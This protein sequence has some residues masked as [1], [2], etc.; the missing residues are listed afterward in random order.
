MIVNR[1]VT[2]ERAQ[3]DRSV[4]Y[5]P[6]GGGGASR[7]PNANFYYF[8]SAIAVFII[9]NGFAISY[10][11]CLFLVVGT[12][13]LNFVFNFINFQSQVRLVRVQ[14]WRGDRKALASVLKMHTRSLGAGDCC[15]PAR[16]V[17]SACPTR[18]H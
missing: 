6:P 9:A 8:C 16:D 18:P 14:R 7:A 10:L 1:P 13:M 2:S 11:Q 15:G 5:A 3:A 17:T 12:L 4:A